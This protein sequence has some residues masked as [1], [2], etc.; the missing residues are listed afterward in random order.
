MLVYEKRARTYD[1]SVAMM[2]W[3]LRKERAIYRALRGKILEVG[4]GSGTNLEF[5]HP[6]A[7][8]T[9][10]DWS[11]T[12]VSYAKRRVKAL[13][14]KNISYIVVGDVRH[15]TDWFKEESFDYV[16]ST[17]L[18]CSVPEPL[19]GLKSIAR[20]L[21]PKGKLVQ[22]EHG[23]SRL[24]SVNFWL[25]L[26]DPMVSKHLGLHLNRLHAQNLK[27]AGFQIRHLREIDPFGILQVII[28]DPPRDKAA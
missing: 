23:A 21:K 16:T 24:K 6:D 17:C 15:L 13:G 26:I 12:M 8:I 25:D 22:L 20:V 4:V 2:E 10:L 28:A 19:L 1:A 27:D 3:F 5:Y 11:P 9:G 14:L 18:F 7:Q